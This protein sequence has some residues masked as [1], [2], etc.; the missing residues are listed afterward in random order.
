MRKTILMTGLLAGL[1]G[2]GLWAQTASE[3][4][5]AGATAE[6]GTADPGPLL[7]PVAGMDGG[8][9]PGVP[10]LAPL[11]S[12]DTD[13]DGLI[14]RAEIET[15]RAERFAAADA[16]GDG[17]LSP[18]ELVAMQEAIRAEVQVARATRAIARMDDDGDGLL[19]SE[20]LA[21]RTP[22]LAPIFDRLDA[23]GDDAISREELAAA[24]PGRGR[25]GFGWGY[26][27]GH[28]RGHGEGGGLMGRLFGQ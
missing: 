17:A 25:E 12:Y 19:S 7:D 23:D 5:E 10:G 13:G 6:A 24:R 1:A 18:A 21:Q 26:G 27:Q 3:A 8:P 16:D 11:E 9:G 4:P 20:E 14:T 15:R 2:T 28:G 22:L